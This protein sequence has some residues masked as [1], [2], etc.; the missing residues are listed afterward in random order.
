VLDLN[1]NN[2]FSMINVQNIL[3]FIVHYRKGKFTQTLGTKNIFVNF[4]SFNGN[5]FNIMKVVIQR[6]LCIN[7]VIRKYRASHMTHFLIDK[8][9]YTTSMTQCSILYATRPDVVA[10]YKFDLYIKNKNT[11]FNKLQGVY[12]GPFDAH[13]TTSQRIYLCQFSRENCKLIEEIKLVVI[14]LIR[15]KGHIELL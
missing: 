9:I 4:P 8:T 15:G 3:T 13:G 12:V 10:F 14:L 6:M 1:L 7:F 2:F 11:N 5:T